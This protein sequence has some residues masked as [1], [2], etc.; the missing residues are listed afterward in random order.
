[1]FLVVIIIIIN[2]KSYYIEKEKKVISALQIDNQLTC[3]LNI[4]ISH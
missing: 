4:D 1:M 3:S 2:N